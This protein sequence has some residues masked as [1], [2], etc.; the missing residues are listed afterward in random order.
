MV[1][2][3]AMSFHASAGW[4]AEPVKIRMSWIAPIS[5]WGSLLLEKKELAQHLGK[6]Y[7]LEP[8]RYVGTPIYSAPGF[9]QAH[10]RSLVVVRSDDEAQSLADLRG[11]RAAYNSTDSQS[12]YNTVR[13]AVAKALQQLATAV[14]AAGTAANRLHPSTTAG[15]ATRAALNDAQI[16]ALLD[17]ERLRLHP[18]HEEN[19]DVLAVG[20]QAIGWCSRRLMSVMREFSD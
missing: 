8:V 10:Y 13:A 3:V 16:T 9:E 12:G 15:E 20:V 14:G 17:R 6:S 4:S 18:G 5:N 11:K 1:F 7:V 2:A 19:I